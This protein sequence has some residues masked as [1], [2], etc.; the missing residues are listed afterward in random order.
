MA[1]IVHRIGIDA[2]APQVYKALA[3]REGL[4]GWWTEEVT[5]ES[6]PGGRI[7]FRFSRPNGDVI[8]GFVMQVAAHEA[9]RR[10]RWNCVEGPDDWVGTEIDFDLSEKDGHTTVL[11]GHRKWRE[12]TEWTAHCSTK[13]ATFLLSLR[14]FVQTGRG[15]PAPHDVRVDDWN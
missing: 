1:D 2:P 14:D 11:F 8:G 15:Q 4:A 7:D 12:T 3:T 13:W 10:V 9:P 6:A 5:G